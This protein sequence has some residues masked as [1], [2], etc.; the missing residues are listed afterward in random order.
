MA[1]ARQIKAGRGRWR[2]YETEPELRAIRNRPGGI[3]M[4]FDTLE[5]AQR[6]WSR[7]HSDRPPL[8]EAAKCARCGGY[9]GRLAASAVHRR[10]LYHVAHAPQVVSGQETG[11]Q[12]S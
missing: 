8:Q 3:F 10:K 9:F 6:W 7:T 5:S 1:E 2:I 11:R 12:Q 4:T